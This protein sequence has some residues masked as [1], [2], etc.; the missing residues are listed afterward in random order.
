MPTGMTVFKS[1]DL[2]AP[3]LLGT[4]HS[5]N[6][7]L[8]ATLLTVG[9]TKPFESGDLNQAVFRQGD[10][11]QRYYLCKDNAHGGGLGDHTLI[12]GY[13]EMT[14]ISSGTNAFPTLDTRAFTRSETLN[15][16]NPLPWIIAADRYT[17]YIFVMARQTETAWH[18]CMIG[19]IYSFKDNDAYQAGLFCNVADIFAASQEPL[20]HLSTHVNVAPAAGA[21]A[22]VLAR[23]YTGAVGAID[24]LSQYGDTAA[25]GAS[26]ET[27]GDLPYP[28][29][30]RLPVA[31]LHIGERTV[32]TVRGKHRGIWHWTM[33][34]SAVS[35]GTTAIGTMLNINGTSV[36]RT[37]LFLK[38]VGAVGNAGVIM[39]ETSD[40][41]DTTD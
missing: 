22:L 8:T 32:P 17:A 5:M 15:N 39:L 19:D 14:S 38:P 31:E 29:N 3:V 1:T 4:G 36:N 30:E 21:A 12:T 25:L 7:L 41:W 37:F 16:P 23:S 28:Q 34:G 26:A 6:D 13:E 35:D 27:F 11:G 33:P 18:G 9:W 40:T 24:T 10:G 2:G 20:V